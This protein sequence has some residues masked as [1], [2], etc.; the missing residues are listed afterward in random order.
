MAAAR[1]AVRLLSLSSFAKFSC[2]S[3]PHNGSVLVTQFH[4]LLPEGL[5]IT[6]TLGIHRVEHRTGAHPT[7]EPLVLSKPQ[8]DRNKIRLKVAIVEVLSH[9]IHAVGGL[10]PDNCLITLRQLF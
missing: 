10:L 4:K 9:G 1:M 7:W 2:S 5:L 6:S 8:N 3:P